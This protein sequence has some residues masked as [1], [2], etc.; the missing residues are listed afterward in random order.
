[1]GHYKIITGTIFLLIGAILFSA[2]FI[3][4][5]I[6]SIEG[7]FVFNKAGLTLIIMSICSFLIGITIILYGVRDLLENTER[8]REEIK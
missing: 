1:M 3:T 8:M 7:A 2:Q 6:L 4:S 5:A